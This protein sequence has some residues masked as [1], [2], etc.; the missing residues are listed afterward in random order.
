MTGDVWI[1][2]EV[3]KRQEWTESGVEQRVKELEWVVELPA[4]DDEDRVWEVTECED[5]IA[6]PT[7]TKVEANAAELDEEG[8]ETVSN[9]VEERHDHHESVDELSNLNDLRPTEHGTY[10]PS[11]PPGTKE[12][13]WEALDVTDGDGFDYTQLTERL[14]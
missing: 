4:Q 14:K 11:P 2:E 10:S 5:D 9:W 3:S 1:A 8:Y 12:G 7:S 13:E 6:K